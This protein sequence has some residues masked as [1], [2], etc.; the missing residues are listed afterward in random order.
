MYLI[1]H[2]RTL[3]PRQKYKYLTCI[4]KLVPT[5]R[6][7]DAIIHYDDYSYPC[8]GMQV[9]DTWLTYAPVINNIDYAKKVLNQA[10]FAPKISKIIELFVE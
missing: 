10:P 2:A 1:Y 7:F 6:F 3:I 4:K 8:I 9:L 5:G